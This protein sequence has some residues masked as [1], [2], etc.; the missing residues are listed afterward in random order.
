MLTLQQAAERLGISSVRVHQLVT[1][2]QLKATMF[3]R[4][5][6]IEEAD[7]VAFERERRPAGRPAAPKRRRQ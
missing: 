7:L 2:G 6:A 3:G 1:A 5:W 4:Q